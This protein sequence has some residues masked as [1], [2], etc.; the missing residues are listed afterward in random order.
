MAAGCWR[1]MARS[2]SVWNWRHQADLLGGGQVAG[3][4]L[5]DTGEHGFRGGLLVRLMSGRCGLAGDHVRGVGLA[6]SGHADV[7][8]LPGQRFGDEEVGGVDGASL[9]DVDVAGVGELGVAGQVDPGDSERSGPGPVQPLPPRLGVG[10]PECGD[11][12][13]VAVGELAAAGV[14][15]GVQ[16]GA[17]QVAD[18]DVVTVGQRGLWR[19]DAAHLS[20]LGL[21]AA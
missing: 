1:A 2:A 14:D 6:A 20:Q 18:A 19:A 11:R 4:A 7:Q 17:D 16:P 10:T 15:L 12:E 5:Q 3:V 13:R 8:G 21:D 9:G